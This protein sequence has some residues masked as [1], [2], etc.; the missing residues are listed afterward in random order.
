[1]TTPDV[2]TA[3]SNA[4]T[5]HPSMA[6]TVLAEAQAAHAPEAPDGDSPPMEAAPAEPA[7]VELEDVGDDGKPR[8]RNLSW[9]DAITQVPPDIRSLM[10]NMRADYTRKTQELAEQRRDFVREREALMKGTA[11]LKDV[12]VPEYDPFNEQTVNARIEAE[13]SRRLREALAPMQ[14]E[15]QTMQAEDSYNTFLSAHPDFKEDNGLRSEVQHLLE[16]NQGLDLETAYW[17][18]KGKQAKLERESERTKRSAERRARKEAAMKGTAAP[19]RAAVGGKPGRANMRKMNN[20][21]LLELA[22][23]MHRNR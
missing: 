19:R 6:E 10:K 15:Y 12:E 23:S 11:T 13:V 18:A 7:D 22:K 5:N 4:P 3:P 1:M 17:A 16:A 20:A 8:T 14:E 9:D 21:D 2:L